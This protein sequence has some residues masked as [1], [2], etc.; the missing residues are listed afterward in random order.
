M[1]PAPLENELESD[2][3]ARSI[4]PSVQLSRT[5]LILSLLVMAVVGLSV[6]A[7]FPDQVGGPDLPVKV[8][9][10]WQPVIAKGNEGAV[11][12]EVL[13]VENL[14]DHDLAKLTID[15][16]GQYLYLQNSPL[17]AKERLVVPQRMFTD[18]RSSQRFNPDKY[19]VQDVA[20]TGQ[21]P[22]GARGIT[23]FDFESDPLPDL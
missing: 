9:L 10:E 13:I 7:L 3:R 8:T 15:I 20:V 16:N 6:Y 19:P 4:A 18:K 11:M 21:L 22:S 5:G 23:Q 1:T 12:T 2:G 14:L 17:L